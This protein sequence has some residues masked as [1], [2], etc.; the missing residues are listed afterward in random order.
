MPAL[1]KGW[2]DPSN[3]T[4]V[5]GR[6]SGCTGNDAVSVNIA[7]AATLLKNHERVGA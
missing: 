2:R 6:L 7:G 4:N 1:R 3:Q 5:D